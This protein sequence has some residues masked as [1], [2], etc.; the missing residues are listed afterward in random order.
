MHL[1]GFLLITVL[2][3][4]SC[5]SNQVPDLDIDAFAAV[6]PAQGAL[7]PQAYRTTVG[8]TLDLFVLEDS[9]FNGKYVIRPSGDII[10][11]KLG[12]I[13][14]VS[15]ALAEVE[16]AVK[17][18]LEATQLKKATVIADPVLRGAET[19]ETVLAGLTVY[20]SGNVAKTGRKFVPFVAGSQVTAFQAVMDAGGFTNF[21]NKKKSFILRK[22]QMG[23]TQRV[24]VDF[25]KIESGVLQD[26]PLRDGDMLV[27]PQK[28]FG[29]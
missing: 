4:A 8:D 6:P 1:R 14:V 2:L 21:A 15:M 23:G 29:F 22:D 16:A 19:G 17:K 18:Q 9:S 20:L 27:V 24:P 10:I 13:G 7:T 3:V 28:M 12:R 26:I 25:S 5:S 11:P